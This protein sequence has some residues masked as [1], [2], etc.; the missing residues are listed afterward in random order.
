MTEN[1]GDTASPDTT[2]AAQGAETQPSLSIVTQY[3]KD[4]S[5]ENPNAPQSLS[6]ENGQPSVELGVNVQAR[7][8]EE[9]MYEVELRI[10]AKAAHGDQIAFVIELVYGGLFQLQNFPPEAMEKICM[11]EC[12]RLIFP[13]ARRIVSDATRDGGFSPLQLD[14]M[15]FTT[16]YVNHKAQAAAAQAHPAGNA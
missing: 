2:A 4:F 14:P 12:P 3:V 13:Y 8:G 16:L 15:D 6:P 7:A 9:N 5:F 1:S 11:I 10:G